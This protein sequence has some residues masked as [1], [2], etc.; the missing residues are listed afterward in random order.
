MFTFPPRRAA[1]FVCAALVAAVVTAGPSLAAT[2]QPTL[3]IA[4]ITCDG[5]TIVSGE[6]VIACLNVKGDFASRVAPS[7]GPNRERHGVAR[8]VEGVRHAFGERRIASV[9]CA[10]TVATDG[11]GHAVACEGRRGE[12]AV[13]GGVS[14]RSRLDPQ[15][16]DAKRITA[17]DGSTIACVDQNGDLSVAG[18]LY[19]E[20]S[21]R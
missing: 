15:D 16:C 2:E 3:V 11:S 13:A 12:L 14:A 21:S 18:D 4:S 1:F 7:N 8:F 19:A 5:A 9:I 20:V 6:T 17:A 10:R